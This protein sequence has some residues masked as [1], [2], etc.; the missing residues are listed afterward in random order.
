[1]GEEHRGRVALVTGASRGIGRAIALRL[2]AEGAEVICVSRSL[3]ACLRVAEEIKKTGGKAQGR[4]VDVS[5]G[6]V[7]RLA[8]DEILRVHGRVDI[9]VNNA[10]I[11]RD[12]LLFRMSEDDWAAV[13]A[14]NLNGCFAWCRSLG[15]PMAQNRWGRII[16]IASVIGLVGNAGQA[17]Y[18]AAKAGII[19]F[20]K[21]IAREL[22]TRNVTAN[23]IAPGFIDTDMTAGLP[24]KLTEQIRGRIP[25][26][27][28]GKPEDIAAAVSFLASDG[29]RYITGQVLAVDG[30]LTMH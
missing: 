4:A 3:E 30:G 16:S 9:L 10:G 19:G 21:S 26:Q 20:T 29:A 25:V 14:T 13:L 28:F 18:A 15:R 2:G 7:V 8:C 6:E 24:E 27:T 1:M 17:N 22:A 23:A 5:H 12:G 11:T